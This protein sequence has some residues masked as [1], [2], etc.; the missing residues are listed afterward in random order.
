MTE[1][2]PSGGPD[3]LRKV[4]ACLGK[5][6]ILRDTQFENWVVTAYFGPTAALDSGDLP[7]LEFTASATTIDKA[8]GV[9]PDLSDGSAVCVDFDSKSVIWWSGSSLEDI[10]DKITKTF[11]T[12]SWEPKET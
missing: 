2:L 3:A 9:P 1:N 11:P 6:K 10:T 5:Q 12:F 8:S 7:A 4:A